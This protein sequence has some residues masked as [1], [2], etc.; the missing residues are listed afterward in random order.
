MLEVDQLRKNNIYITIHLV[1]LDL[2]HIQRKSFSKPH[3]FLLSSKMTIRV[4][5][6]GLSA[7]DGTGFRTGNWGVQA[8]LAPLILSPHYTIVAIC[9]STTKSAQAAIDF[10][11][12]PSSVKAYGSPEELANDPDVDLVAV[13]VNVAK[14]FLLGKPALLTKKDVF[15]EWPLGASLGEAEELAQLANAQGVKTMVGLQLRADP[16]VTKIKGLLKEG[17][18]G[19]VTSS[20]AWGCSSVIPADMWIAD[21]AYYLDMKSGGNEF[22]IFFGHSMVVYIL[23]EDF[24]ADICSP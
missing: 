13:S 11:K 20:M 12:L 10:H 17:S 5:I 21:A 23:D 3:D 9:N 1:Q 18:I 14:H 15:M 2:A 16:L 7:H 22:Y 4:A 8:H 6:I 19:R 24:L